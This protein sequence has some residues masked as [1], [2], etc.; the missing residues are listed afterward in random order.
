M[1]TESK[2]DQ[3]TSI[4]SILNQSVPERYSFQRKKLFNP[5]EAFLIL[6]H[7]N[8][9]NYKNDKA[10]FV[11]RLGLKSVDSH[12]LNNAIDGYL[13]QS[14]NNVFYYRRKLLRE[15][16]WRQS[17]A[18]FTL[19][20]VVL[21]PL[22]V[23]KFT[24]K[25]VGGIFDDEASNGNPKIEETVQKNDSTKTPPESPE[26]KQASNTDGVVYY[27]KGAHQSSGTFVHSAALQD[28]SE[29]MQPD[30]STSPE[31]VTPRAAITPKTKNA[32]QQKSAEDKSSTG[33]NS[34][35]PARDPNNPT[36]NAKEDSL[37]SGETPSESITNEGTSDAKHKLEGLEAVGIILS[38]LL[39]SLFAVHHVVSQWAS[40][41]KF[42]AH[43]HQAK[44]DLMDIHYGLEQAG[45]NVFRINKG[46]YDTLGLTEALHKATDDCRS[47]VNTETRGYF[48]LSASPV[49]ELG[50][51]FSK[52]MATANG[53]VSAFTS[54]RYSSEVERM[55]TTVAAQESYQKEMGDALQKLIVEEKS[56]VLKL[57]K[58]MERQERFEDELAELDALSSTNDIER[59]KML[60]ERLELLEDKIDEAE[61]ALE[62]ASS[63]V[64]LKRFEI[65][66]NERNA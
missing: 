64:E 12:D 63:K 41:R 19:I 30:G 46:K 29:W 51:V 55:R 49:V 21:V 61:I 60:A 14:L 13:K 1:D 44:M 48:E 57:R 54:K 33:T 53:L 28:S 42:R 25:A 39:T 8:N 58:L 56:L 50:S 37:N 16:F 52:S 3:D 26:M 18:L 43:F 9:W 59:R 4:Y 36:T 40:K 62:D 45:Q 24:D 47:I 31:A 22:F 32:S 11:E 65:A 2:K 17:Y 34:G 38:L 66:Q 5:I 10:R 15:N 7:I 23:F 35:T 6:F 27:Y 20:I